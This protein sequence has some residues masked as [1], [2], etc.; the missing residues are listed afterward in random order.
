MFFAIVLTVWT[1]MH[2]YV[3]WRAPSI[4]LVRRRISP[5]WLWSLGLLAWS[6]YFVANALES[7]A[8]TAWLQ[9]AA[10]D[11]LGILFLLFLA[12][13]CADLLTAFGFLFRRTAPIIRGWALMAGLF[14]AMVA[15]IQGARAPA[16]STY[17]VA[18]PGLAREFDGA[19]IIEVSDLHLGS[20]TSTRW[21]AERLDQIEALRPDLIILAGDIVEGHGSDTARF[22]PALRRLSAPLGV[23]AVNGNHEGYGEG[24]EA[25][26]LS[27]AGIPL[28]RDRWVELRPGL[29]I[30][31]VDDLTRQRRRSGETGA[32]VEHALA[33]R[34]A[35]ATT[36]FVSHT[37]WE[38][39][40]VAAQKVAVMFSGHTHNGQIW[41]FTYFVRRLYRS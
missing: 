35:N 41:P 10:S 24:S 34:P 36:L 31:G 20:L 5:K 30:A 40:R 26:L 9:I 19:T 29:V 3:F 6:S 23:W 18:V 4:P 21:L 8:W 17:E 13:L 7:V 27:Q 14:L 37:P 25:G 39:Q 2:A 22:L 11:W 1:V 12:L 38:T 32:S 33:G 16:V 28:L 15:L